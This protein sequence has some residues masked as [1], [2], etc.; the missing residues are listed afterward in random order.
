MYALLFDKPGRF[1]KGNLHTHSTASDGLLTPETVCQVYQN[2]GYNFI[3]VTDHFSERYGFPVTDTRPF[4]TESFITIPGAEL[5]APAT[6]LGDEWH[7]LAVGLPTNFAPT[8]KG[9]TG[10]QLAERALEAGAYVAAA[11]PGWYNLSENDICSLGPIHAVE[12]YNGTAIDDSDRADAWYLLDNLLA[13]GARYLACATDD[14]HFDPARS[15][16]MRAWVLVKSETLS[17]EAILGALKAGHY[18]SS[19]GPH[20]H[21]IRVMPGER[22]IVNCSPAERVFVT[23]KGAN[24]AAGFGTNMVEAEISLKEFTSPFCRVTVRDA[25]GGKAWSNPIWFE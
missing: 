1:W 11:H 19:T 25:R 16:A 13:R 9:E 18:Y 21:N 10:V 15:D 4:W 6:E 14:A 3:A 8:A 24:F 23:G 5:H 17:P 12:T 7:I 20:I 2:A 22:I